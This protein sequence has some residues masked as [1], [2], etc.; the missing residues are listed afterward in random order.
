MNVVENDSIRKPKTYVDSERK[1]KHLRLQNGLRVLLISDKSLLGGGLT[2]DANGENDDGEDEEEDDEK[3]ESEDEEESSGS[4]DDDA[5]M[6]SSSS[7][8]GDGEE[9]EGENP[10]EGLKTA[11]C[12][13]EVNVG[14]LS[15]PEN[16]HGLSHF[17]EHMVFMGTRTHASENFF[18]EW[19]SRNW[20]S[21]NAYTDT[22]KTVFHFDVHPKHLK[23][24]V[25]IF[26]KFFTEP[27]ILERALERE[28]TA[29][30]S[31]FERVVNSDGVRMELLLADLAMGIR[32]GSLGGGTGSR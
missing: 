3:M 18:D 8:E 11:A 20:G 4:D 10:K 16:F 22:E 13:V 12:A 6:T 21:Q 25:E 2:S 30:E 7:M 29:I 14:Y 24:G 26:S 28:V 32:T 1:F 5:S 19:L 31:E 9:E 17:L 15:D 27:L 23:E